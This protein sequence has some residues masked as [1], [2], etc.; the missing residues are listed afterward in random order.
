MS[1]LG[2]PVLGN[3]LANQLEPSRSQVGPPPRRRQHQKTAVLGNQVAAFAY[4]PSRP[5]QEPIP[6]LEMQ[7]GRT[8]GQH[9]HP[10]SA[11]LDDVTQDLPHRLGV[12]QIMMLLQEFVVPTPIRLRLDEPHL[13]L[14]E[15]TSLDRQS[16]HDLIQMADRKST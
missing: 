7:G 11:I 4:L 10:L 5:L 8:E 16:D 14:L 15:Q 9:R 13:N 6:G 2:L 1:K 12:V 3:A